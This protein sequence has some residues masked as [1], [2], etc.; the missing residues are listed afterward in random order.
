MK[1]QGR[2]TEGY[3]HPRKKA[4]RKFIQ[5]A[6]LHLSHNPQ[7]GYN[8]KGRRLGQLK[9]KDSQIALNHQTIGEK[10][11]F[12][13]NVPNQTETNTQRKYFIEQIE[14]LN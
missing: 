5:I 7:I 2:I 10:N 12:E 3:T 4:T 8:N 11:S 1:R 6:Y 14:F 9:S 13:R